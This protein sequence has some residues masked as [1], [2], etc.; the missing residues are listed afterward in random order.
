MRA[1]QV[2]AVVYCRELFQERT[3]VAMST[4]QFERLIGNMKRRLKQDTV[5]QTGNLP[6][7]LS[8]WQILIRDSLIPGAQNPHSGAG[9]GGNCRW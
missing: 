8:P 3:G 1:R 6:I 9:S 7:N 5:K 4:A 2:E